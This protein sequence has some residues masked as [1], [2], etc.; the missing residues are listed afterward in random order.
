M[1]KN[2]SNA[3]KPYSLGSALYNCFAILQVAGLKKRE[4]CL[5]I[6]SSIA[7]FY[8]WKLKYHLKA[9]TTIKT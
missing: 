9:S 8:T 5:K 2:Q 3:F 1:D 6:K 7:R 4:L